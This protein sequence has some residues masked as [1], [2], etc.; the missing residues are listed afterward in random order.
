MLSTLYIENLAVIEKACI[1]FL[2]GFTVFTGETGAGKSIVIDAINTCLGQR[3][4]REIVRTGTQKSSVMAIFT[5]ITKEVA[6]FLNENG[7]E[8]TDNEL[9]IVREIFSDGRSTAKIMGKPA[10]V[11]FL[12][13]LGS[14]LVNIHGQHDNQILL[15]PDRHLDIIDDYG[16]LSKDILN[17]R[18]EFDILRDNIRALRAVTIDE[19]EKRRKIDTLTYQIDEISK[20]S[21]EPHIE[22]E[23]LEESKLLKNSEKIALALSTVTNALLGDDDSSSGACDLIYTAKNA[24]GDI[25]DFSIFE[26]SLNALESLSIDLNEVA[27]LLKEELN[28]LEYDPIKADKIERQ[29]SDIH[30]LKSKYG[31]T[32]EEVIAFK[33][34]AKAELL[35]I[36]SADEEVKRLNE[37]A[38]AQKEKV[39]ALAKSL[40]E[41]RKQVSQRFIDEVSNEAKFLEMPNLKLDARFTPCKLNKNGDSTVEL[42][43]SAN[44][45]EPP[46]P[47]AKIASG[48]ELSRIMLAIKSALADK[49][50]IYTLIFDEIDTGVS[51]KASQKIGL[52]LKQVA[53]NRKVL[54]VT[55]SAQIASLAHN[56]L[57]IKKR[58]EDNRTFTDVIALND[59]ERIYEIAR[60]MSTDK[61]TDLMLQNAENML[62]D[63]KNVF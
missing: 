59:N 45:G 35:R 12:K 27:T 7:Y 22:E 61:V 3:A 2:T 34:E 37:I 36:E 50:K 16:E 28:K 62:I 19:N 38:I 40:T 25:S 57:L 48:G 49:D 1:D 32:V 21:L 43:I 29:L 63:G 60:I 42:L 4:N 39:I 26:K 51:G 58:T 31:A 17:Y 46:K 47:I 30:H 52:K 20:A 10:T 15:N 14:M 6:D 11:N 24:L 53:R 5:D 56:Q 44:A 55:H 54:C 8:T 18:Q 33:E 41:K 13:D 9:S 23:L